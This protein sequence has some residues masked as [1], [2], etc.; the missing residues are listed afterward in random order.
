MGFLKSIFGPSEREITW[1]RLAYQIGG[2]YTE[3]S[4]TVDEKLQFDFK[5]WTITLDTYTE[6]SSSGTGANKTTRSTTYTRFRA[7]Y[8]NADG[9]RF[10]IYRASI[11][12][13]IGTWLGMQDLKIGDP[14]FDD[15]FVIKAKD[16]GRAREFFADQ[17]IRS[18]IEQHRSF[19]F[20]VKDD[21][22]WFGAHFPEGVDELYFTTRGEIRHPAAIKDVFM[23]FGACLHRLCQMGSAY[24]DDPGAIH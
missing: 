14:F 20:E 12:S 5:G 4:W 18:F 21:E 7:P 3:G 2:R 11:F 16:E 1:R 6:T 9:F 15:E 13:G 8:V 23:M 17:K 10:T 19:H 22:G 24:E